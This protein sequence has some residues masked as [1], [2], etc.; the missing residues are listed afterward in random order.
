MPLYI[1][2]AAHV[3]GASGT[4]WRSDLEIY[5][6]GPGQGFIEVSMLAKDQPNSA[7]LTRAFVISPGMAWR[8][9]DVLQ[10]M[11]GVSG[12]A[13]LRVSEVDNSLV[14][15]SR[16]FNDTDAGTYG[17]FIGAL[18]D[19][20]AIHS[21]ERGRIVQLSQHGSP[22]SGYRTNVGFLNGTDDQMTVTVDLYRAGGDRLGTKLVTLGPYMFKQIDRIFTTVTED[23]VEDGFVTVSTPTTGGALFAYGSV[24][25]NRTGDPIYI[26]AAA[27]T[28]ESVFVPA[29]AHVSG[30]VG[31]NWRTD[32]ELLNPGAAD[33]H[34]EISMLE[35]DHDNSTPTSRIQQVSAGASV[36]LSDVLHSIFS[37]EG[38][39]ALRVTPLSGAEVLVT[40]RTFNQTPDGTYGQFVGAVAA[41][42][43]I[44]DG[45]QGLIVELTHSR[46]TASGYRTNLGYLNCTGSEASVRIDLYRSNGV[47]L[48]TVEDTVGPFM[49]RQQNRIFQQVTG[50]DVAD[51]F[52]II[53]S[54]TPGSRLIAYASVV[55]N[56]TGDPIYL[57]ATTVVTQPSEPTMDPRATMH[58]LFRS[59]DTVAADY[60]VEDMAAMLQTFGLQAALAALAVAN[61]DIV[62]VGPDW[63]TVDYGDGY[64]LH[65]GN[66]VSGRV[67]AQF[68]DVVI[69][70]TAV[71]G[72]IDLSFDE[73]QWNHQ[74]P[75]VDTVAATVDLAVDPQGHVTGTTS[76][77]G[78]GVVPVKSEPVTLGGEALWNTLLC[79]RYPVGGAITLEVGG[80]LLTFTFTPV[81]DGSF[82]YSE[83]TGVDL[84]QFHTVSLRISHVTFTSRFADPVACGPDTMTHTV[85]YSWGTSEGSFAGNTY[86]AAW[87][88]TLW[89]A[90][91]HR[92]LTVALNSS[93]TRVDSFE[94]L[95]QAVDPSDP[96]NVVTTTVTF[97]G[98]DLA[99]NCTAE[100][101]STLFA[102]V[103]T[104]DKITIQYEQSFSGHACVWIA[105]ALDCENFSGITIDIH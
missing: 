4:N 57:P 5:N 12:S 18:G 9:R 76:F 17:Q 73:L 40:S 105:D 23:D 96:D 28:S 100:G 56:R 88:D 43:T 16:T 20:H 24:V 38:T 58:L 85:T 67:N 11:F 97:S 86:Q 94:A 59:L 60:D 93:T 34:Y 78:S 32:L 3:S 46:G 52:A 90:E 84:S 104:C 68:T 61:P 51:G 50:D 41:S 1:P 54:T 72:R 33:A 42:D 66:L 15:T 27:V 91:F 102:G 26:P 103:G 47:L 83:P 74:A 2:A 8:Y 79:D 36:R 14:V 22:D 98:S 44:T 89:G 95:E 77:S 55:D 19:S 39:A 45:K 49:H 10:A 6:L 7:P 69:N 29:T 99:T 82:G 30:A 81:C 48:G 63:F 21:G 13:A 87:D 35:T 65:D 92:A 71:S 62:T 75:P 80:F 53:A 25:D 64:R 37:F 70:A 31:T 101:C